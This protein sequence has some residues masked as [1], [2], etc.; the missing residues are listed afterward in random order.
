MPQSERRNSEHI[1]GSISA[2]QWLGNSSIALL[3]VLACFLGGASQKW[4]EGIVVALLGLYLVVRPP[5]VSLGASTNCIL[6]GLL[7]LAAIAFLPARWFFASIWRT[8]LVDDF[9]ISLPSTITP[10][11]WLTA[12]CLIS[13]IAG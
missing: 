3:P 9:G 2:S 7:G 12:G 6:V 1:R 11:P 5:D 10:Q 8:A 4:A 13:L